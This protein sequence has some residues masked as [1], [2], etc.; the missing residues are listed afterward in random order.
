SLSVTLIIYNLYK[1]E[2]IIFKMQLF[3]ELFAPPSSRQFGI[4]LPPAGS[5]QVN[6]T[7]GKQS[8]QNHGTAQHFI[9]DQPS[10]HQG[11]QWIDV[12]VHGNGG[13]REFFQCIGEG[14]V[15]N[16]GAENNQIQQ[17]I[18]GFP[19]KI[20]GLV[21]VRQ[22][23]DEQHEHAPKEKLNTRGENRLYDWFLFLEDQGAGSPGER[24]QHDA[25]QAGGVGRIHQVLQTL[26]ENKQQAAEAQQNAGEYLSVHLFT[27]SH[28]EHVE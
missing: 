11:H 27:V 22:G 18:Q 19:G 7:N 2:E 25:D 21:V 1:V 13:G 6:T 26:A 20:Y 9:Q 17:R 4:A 16:H 28:K 5:N 24:S 8:G 23:A 14:T 12:G 3:R 15:G 10:G